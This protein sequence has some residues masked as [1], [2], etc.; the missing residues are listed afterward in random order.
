[1][2][3][4]QGHSFSRIGVV[5]G[6]YGRVWTPVER[7]DFITALHPFGLNTYLY[8]PKHESALGAELLAPLSK[9]ALERLR[10]LSDLCARLGVALWA[11]L[12]LEPPF[13][14]GQDDHLERL[15]GK[16]LALLEMGVTG[17][18]VLFDDVPSGRSAV[19]A[20]GQDPFQGSL[21]AAQAHAFNTLQD[22]VTARNGPAGTSIAWA[23][24]PGRYSLDPLIEKTSGT[25]E[26]DYLRKLH[27]A[28]P[29]AVPF[30]WTGPQ[31]CS[32][33]VTLSDREAYL[34]ELGR[35]AIDR[36]LLLWDNY[37]VNDA[38]MAGRL[39][40]DPLGGRAG[41]LPQ[42]VEGYLFNPMLQPHLGLVPGATCLTYASNP[43]AYDPTTAWHDAVS[44]LLPAAVHQPFA[45]LSVLTRPPF[46]HCGAKADWPRGSFPL[47]DRLQRAWPEVSMGEPSEPYLAGDMA[48]VLNQLDAGL[49]G[50]WKAEAAPWVNRL[51]QATSL[52]EAIRDGA[53][54]EA[55]GPMR[56]QF[57]APYIKGPLPEVLGPWFP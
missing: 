35:G 33:A 27:E 48:R 13:D 3:D 53:P 7:A 24:C 14:P 55:I 9:G 15:T 21:A 17:L 57:V 43:T 44:A 42:G 8:A 16:A 32:Q 11:G 29:E 56:A 19:S 49:P 36:P 31:V 10:P 40:L 47:A 6:F 12:H 38:H 28:L 39:H 5:E 22:R 51:R 46:A 34:A 2:V 25:F 18:A 37:P 41:D 30:L 52:L 1:M 23:V 4:R 54:P 26:P 20:A 45:E 50:D